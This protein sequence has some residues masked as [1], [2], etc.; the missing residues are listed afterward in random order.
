ME[1]ECNR[2][3][4]NRMPKTLTAI[5]MIN[6]HRIKIIII[7][8]STKI[9]LIIIIIKLIILTIIMTIIIEMIIAVIEMIM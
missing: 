7:I 5:I 1:G 3:M 6:D 9:I 4:K 8:I 2:A